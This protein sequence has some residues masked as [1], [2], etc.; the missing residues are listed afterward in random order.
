[1]SAFIGQ[2]CISGSGTTLGVS[3]VDGS[4]DPTNVTGVT[5]GSVQTLEI[6]G[7][8][9]TFALTLNGQTLTLPFGVFPS[10]TDGTSGVGTLQAALETIVGVGNVTVVGWTPYKI[11]FTTIQPTITVDT[12]NVTAT[13]AADPTTAGTTPLAVHP[14]TSYRGTWSVTSTGGGYS[15]SHLEATAGSS[16]KEA[17]WVVTGLV[18]GNYQILASWPGGVGFATNA[19][20]R[21]YDGS[22]Y[23]GKMVVNQTATSGGDVTYAVSF[24]GIGTF[25]TATGTLTIVLTDDAN[26]TVAA[27]AIVVRPV[28]PSVTLTVLPLFTTGWVWSS[29]QYW[30]SAGGADAWQGAAYRA[31]NALGWWELPYRGLRPGNYLV[32]LNYHADAGNSTAAPITVRMDA[33]DYAVAVNQTLPPSGGTHND[34]ANNIGF[35]PL[36]YYNVVKGSGFKFRVTGQGSAFSS[37]SAFAVTRISLTGLSES[38]TS[39]VTTAIPPSIKVNGGASVP[40]TSS[41]WAVNGSLNYVSFFISAVNPGD[42]V[43]FSAPEGA[44]ETAA[45]EVAAI[46]NAAVTNAT[47]SSIL[48][49]FNSA[50]TRTLKLGWNVFT[51]SLVDV[52]MVYTDRMKQCTSFVASAGD[53]PTYN[54]KGEVV[55]GTAYTH[56][57]KSA[58]L[59][60]IN[61]RGYNSVAAGT[62]TVKWKGAGT[63]SL[64]FDAAPATDVTTVGDVKTQLYT[65]TKQANKD[66]AS[67]ALTITGPV[68][69]L[70]IYPPGVP[71]DGSQVFHPEYL[72]MLQGSAVLRSMVWINPNNNIIDYSD[73]PTADDV[74]YQ[75]QGFFAENFTIEKFEPWSGDGWGAPGYIPIL[76]TVDRAHGFVDGS[77]GI[78]SG[79]YPAAI[80]VFVTGAVD[81]NGNPVPSH[82]FEG[83]GQMIHYA[84]LLMTS[85]QFVI[86]IAGGGQFQGSQQLNPGKCSFYKRAGGPLDLY[87]DLC[88]EVGCDAWVNTTESMTDACVTAMFTHVATH[89]DPSRLCYME[90]MN[91]PWNYFFT[92]YHY[93]VQLGDF[94]GTGYMQ[95]YASRAA[96]HQELARAAFQAAG[97]DPEQIQS[98]F[99]V[100]INSAGLADGLV[101]WCDANNK[102]IDALAMATYYAVGPQ[103]ISTAGFDDVYNAL[104]TE[105]VCDLAEYQNLFVETFAPRFAEHRA[106]LDAH[107][108]TSAKLLAYEMGPATASL[109]GSDENQAKHTQ[110]LHQHPRFRHILLD[111]YKE[112]QDAGCVLGCL[113][114][115]HNVYVGEG[116]ANGTKM[117]GAYTGWDQLAGKG[118]G[119]DGKA[120]NRIDPWN[121]G[122]HVSVVGQ[123]VLE[124]NAVPVAAEPDHVTIRTRWRNPVFRTR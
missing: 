9:G 81:E 114:V 74:S 65:V 57:F 40:I 5:L 59:N 83:Y 37:V 24:E 36:G 48:P 35:T 117:Y 3:F 95:A 22:T 122:A 53:P 6:T 89:L 38:V 99:N 113:Y 29:Y 34:G 97:R 2:A 28:D 21:V 16:Y 119:S 86:T 108:Y 26:G 124:W 19:T 88:N 91:E 56:Y 39:T 111:S 8:G 110:G 80:Q 94:M 18:A 92:F 62:W 93:Y 77:L 63:P 107:G 109:G 46:T 96:H 52:A 20:F 72:R 4:G 44:I 1:M 27:D 68:T 100:F 23:V 42:T 98:V 101:T 13:R 7:C 105:Q 12:T 116:S 103:Q 61:P 85:D 58:F 73:I 60:P 11:T 90:T 43:T 87:I 49:A 75:N 79:N 104:T 112:L 123:S 76:V 71:T 30:G 106:I 50:A 41:L 15:G 33:T 70:H 25:H 82:V 121:T 10:N 115:I 32:E 45:G 66:D 64:G 84:P 120:D 14:V 31:S 67:L 17:R 47:G 54:A 118:D 51:E 78:F 69:D 55:S 102:R